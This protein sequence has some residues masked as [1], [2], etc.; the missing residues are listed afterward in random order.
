MDQN[1]LNLEILELGKK[2]CQILPEDCKCQ[3]IQKYTIS[4]MLHLKI[5]TFKTFKTMTS[6]TTHLKVNFTF[7]TYQVIY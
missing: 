1:E 2:N 7:K 3:L 5:E 4:Y 6:T